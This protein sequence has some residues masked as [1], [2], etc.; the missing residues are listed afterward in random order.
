[1]SIGNNMESKNADIDK[2][3]LNIKIVDSKK[4]KMDKC[5]QG[6]KIFL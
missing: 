4:P 1:M 5:R 2:T 3:S 6:P